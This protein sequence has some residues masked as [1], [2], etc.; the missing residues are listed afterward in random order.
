[1]LKSVHELNSICALSK[2]MDS[3]SYDCIGEDEQSVEFSMQICIDSWMYNS[4]RV[5]QSCFIIR[6]SI[7]IKKLP[8]IYSNFS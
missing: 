4:L 1:M 5:A 7:I 2:S 6:S 3:Y 8:S